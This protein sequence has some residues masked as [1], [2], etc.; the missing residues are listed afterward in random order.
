MQTD[1][2]D[3]SV[4]VYS[5][6]DIE[7]QDE[8]GFTNML[9]YDGQKPSGFLYSSFSRPQMKWTPKNQKPPTSLYQLWT[10]TGG[11]SY[12]SFWNFLDN[13]Y[14]LLFLFWNWL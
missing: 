8:L 9:H 11:W 3:Y 13:D 10:M 1:H 12:D 14:G 4:I 6:H 5:K 7:I 2:R